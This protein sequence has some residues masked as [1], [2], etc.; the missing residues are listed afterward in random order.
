M[1]W[2]GTVRS[3]RA[4]YRAAERDA[5]RRQ[6]EL[7]R[8]QKEQERM[9]ELQ[10]AAYEVE[11]Y[12]NYI[13][14]L[15]SVH[16]ECGPK[17]D[18]HSIASSVEPQQPLRSNAR[19]T[20]ARR[21]EATYK[22]GLLDRLL[23]REEVKRAE[24]ATEVE[25]ARLA[26]DAAHQRALDSWRQEIQE[27]KK[28]KEL[29][30]RVLALEPKGLIEAIEEID[31]FSDVSELGTGINFRTADSG[32]LEAIIT[33]HSDSVVPKESKSLLKSGRLSVKQMP[34]GKFNELFQDY[35]CG[36]VLRVANELFALLPI[37]AVIVTAEDTLLNSATGHLEETPIV[38]ALIPR[39][40]M[41]RLNL[42][43]LDPSDS[44]DNFVH[45]MNFK[46]T[47]GF[48]GVEKLTPEDYA[49]QV[50]REREPMG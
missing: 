37:E 34:K 35:V 14:V 17:V 50:R 31:P 27:C 38:S 7:E 2:K 45:R 8:Q 29:A 3:V 41:A 18:W 22:P 48:E 21:A 49:S 47:K 5:R 23:K 25:R 4:A 44:M 28:S 6:R 40:S 1:G 9:A 33:V 15:V 12:E 16:T 13:Q 43:H 32:F 10:R 39:A 19:E 46:K 11:R 42:E 20:E 30:A 26:D 36:C 24:L